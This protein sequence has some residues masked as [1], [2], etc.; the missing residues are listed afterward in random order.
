M[1][2]EVKVRM[3]RRDDVSTLVAFNMQMAKETEDKHLDLDVLTAGVGAIFENPEHGFYLVAEVNGAVVGSLMVTTEWSDWRNGDYWWIQSVYVQSE[4]RQKGIFRA[5]YEE[6]H[7]RAE[8]SNEV[9]GVRLYV[10]K[11]NR[12]AQTVYTRRGLTETHYKIFEDI[13]S[14]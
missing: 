13:F 8:N 2:D 9:C 6:V 14:E 3:A 11:G 4:F 10:E 5:L 1:K 7:E 12:T